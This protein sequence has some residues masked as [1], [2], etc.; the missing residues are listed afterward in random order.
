M[1][2]MDDWLIDYNRYR[3]HG[4]LGLMTPDEFAGKPVDRRA[5]LLT[6]VAG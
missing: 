5:H 4:S 6:L 2:A 3:P 1:V